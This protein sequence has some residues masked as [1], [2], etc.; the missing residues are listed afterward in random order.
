MAE[1]GLLVINERR[2]PWSCEGSMPQCRRMP[3]QGGEN[4]GRRACRKGQSISIVY[5]VVNNKTIAS[6]MLKEFPC[7]QPAITN[8][9][10]D[11]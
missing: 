5:V 9:M 6:F 11:H 10:A 4:F 3:G 8:W 7:N 1:D 2:G